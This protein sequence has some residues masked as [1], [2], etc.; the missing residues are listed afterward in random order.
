M[1]SAKALNSLVWDK[2]CAMRIL[3][4]PS[5]GENKAEGQGRR[6]DRRQV[7]SNQTKY[8]VVLYALPE[9]VELEA[10]K[11]T[12]VDDYINVNTMLVKN[13]IARISAQ[14]AKSLGRKRSLRG[15]AD[16]FGTEL[17]EA[18]DEVQDYATREHLRK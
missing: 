8:E 1:P 2:N 10:Q 6:P 12:P 4:A 7:S 17:L 15:G 16:V 11:E 5:S 9:V 13:G 14:A 3:S 18:L